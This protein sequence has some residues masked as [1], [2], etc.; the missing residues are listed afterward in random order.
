MTD[1]SMVKIGSSTDPYNDAK[2]RGWSITRGADGRVVRST[3]GL[4]RGERL[5]TSLIDGEV[6]SSIDEVRT[7]PHTPP[8]TTERERDDD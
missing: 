3:T 5:V 4:S 1:E 7:S 8:T 6:T 2:A